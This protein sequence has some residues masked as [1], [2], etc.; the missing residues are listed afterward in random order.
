MARIRKITD[1]VPLGFEH[2]FVQFFLCLRIGTFLHDKSRHL[3]LL[4][5]SFPWSYLPLTGMSELSKPPLANV[6]SWKVQV[7]SRNFGVELLF[8]VCLNSFTIIFIITSL[9]SSIAISR[10]EWKNRTLLWPILTHV[11][12]GLPLKFWNETGSTRNL[13]ISLLLFH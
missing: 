13:L 9:L 12:T 4:V 8:I 2:V 5:Y 10:I 7:C 3:L 1:P 11:N 6:V